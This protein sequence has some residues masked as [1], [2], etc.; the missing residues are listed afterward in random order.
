MKI[1]L[2]KSIATAFIVILSYVG[3]AQASSVFA[4]YQGGTG[5]STPPTIGQVLVGQSDGT[6]GPQATSTL[7]ITGSGGGSG[8]VTSITATSPLTGG[9]ITTSGSIGCQSASGSQA[10]C[11]SST[12]WTTFN[13]KQPAGSYLTSNGGDWAG[14]WQTYSPSNFLTGLSTNPF[15]ASY[16]QATSTG[17]STFSGSLVIDQNG[18]T[19]AVS[20]K[21]GLQVGITNNKTNTSNQVYVGDIGLLYLPQYIG[22]WISRGIWGI[23]PNSSSSDD[24]LRIGTTTAA[25]SNWSTN[26]ANFKVSI[27]NSTF[28][29]SPSIT[30]TTTTAGLNISNLTSTVLAVD[31]NHNVIATTTSGGGGS[32]TPW[33]SNIDGG[34]YGLSNVSTISS[35]GN[36]SIDVTGSNTGSPRILGLAN[37]TSGTAARFQFGDG[38]NSIQTAFGARQVWQ[39][40]WG[41]E[42]HGSRQTVGSYAPFNTGAS[43]DANLNVVNDASD[44]TGLA[45]TGYSSQTASLQE[46]RNSGG[47]A[48]TKVGANGVIYPVQAPTASAP[49]YVKGGIYFDTTLNKLRIGGASGWETVTSI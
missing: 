14:T 28:G 12:D 23:G 32:Q 41:L 48:L 1:T 25:G 20:I 7:G 29:T 49:S 4:P 9:A 33:T 42:I 46:W 34:G 39:G 15:Q 31:A 18:T 19:T 17:T 10:G 27:G 11:L 13:N 26:Q 44:V 8:T 37:L 45:V 36:T 16:F 35:T 38:Y 43:S 47:T 24:T 6:Y 21:T 40:Y 30:G 3:V 22:N 2:N 5:T